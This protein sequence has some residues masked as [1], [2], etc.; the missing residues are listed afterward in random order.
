MQ[1][2]ALVITSRDPAIQE[3]AGEAA[4]AVEAD[5]TRALSQAMEA[6]VKRPATFTALREK[7]LQ[8][9]AGFTWERTAERTRDVY[10]LAMRAF[11]G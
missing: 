6:A 5:D 2:G 4:V 8:R 1:C 11:R 7:A 3:V 10:E 9:A